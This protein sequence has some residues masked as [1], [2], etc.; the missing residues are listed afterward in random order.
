[1][2]DETARPQGAELLEMVMTPD[3]VGLPFLLCKLEGGVGE[4][5]ANQVHIGEDR[6]RRT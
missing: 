2:V 4:E 3:N 6:E 5:G 1:L